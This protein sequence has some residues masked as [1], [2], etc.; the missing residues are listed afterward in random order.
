MGFPVFVRTLFFSRFFDGK[1]SLEFLTGAIYRRKTDCENL[2]FTRIFD[3]P[4]KY[5]EFPS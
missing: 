1:S 5:P 4:A 3:R 2:F